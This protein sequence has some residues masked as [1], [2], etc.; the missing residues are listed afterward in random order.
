MVNICLRYL[1]LN[2]SANDGL[3]LIH[4]GKGKVVWYSLEASTSARIRTVR[5]C[6]SIMFRGDT[7]QT[8]FKETSG[9]KQCEPPVSI[10]EAA[11]LETD[12]THSRYEVWL[13][14]E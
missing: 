9:N 2:Q 5:R 11:R 10:D 8:N 4:D 1:T 7:L 3:D 6:L 12:M 14:I 13:L